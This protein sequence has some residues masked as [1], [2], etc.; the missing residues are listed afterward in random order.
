M[1]AIRKIWNWL[2]NYPLFATISLFSVVAVHFVTSQRW[3]ILNIALKL[4]KTS[5]DDP[6]GILTSL[7][8]GVAGVSA[9][10]GG[11]AGVVVIF[12]LGTENDRFRLLRTKGNQ[13]L[14]ANWISVVLSSFA[15][16]FGAI[17]ASVIVVGF[18]IQA[19]MWVL[20]VC[21]LMAAH[22]AIR[23]TCL[24]A[25]LAKIVDGNDKEEEERRSSISTALVIPDKPPVRTEAHPG[26]GT[27][28]RSQSPAREE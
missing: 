9:M 22:A 13:R 4:A 27:S 17:A 20:E 18:N 7:A 2:V 3:G 11:F 8:L 12:G 25:G 5:A 19:G 21:A 15:G 28:P 14:R 10:V 1:K 23:L 24:L 6:E 16:A 26:A